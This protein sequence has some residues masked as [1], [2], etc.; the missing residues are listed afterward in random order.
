[1][2]DITPAPIQPYIFQDLKVPERDVVRSILIRYEWDKRVFLRRRNTGAGQFTYKGGVRFGQPG[3][4]DIDGFLL[5]GRYIA[6]ECKSSTGRQS[7]E[8][9]AFQAIVEQ[10]GG[11]YILAKG[12]TA[13]DDVENA[14]REALA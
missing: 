3:D 13:L 6:V 4:P 9:K 1:M 11:L 2:T 12:Q 8:Q 7:P 10:Y 14:I 5:G